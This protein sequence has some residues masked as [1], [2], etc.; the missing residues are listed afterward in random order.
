[1]RANG[2]KVSKVKI[3]FKAT[4]DNDARILINGQEAGILKAEPVNELTTQT[5]DIPQ[6]VLTETVEVK[7]STNHSKETPAIYEIRLMLK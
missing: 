5:L 6:P 7:V 3:T 2:K 4:N 1:M